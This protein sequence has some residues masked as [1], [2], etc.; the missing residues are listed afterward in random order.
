MAAG[1]ERYIGVADVDVGSV[2]G[3]HVDVLLVDA[4]A[5]AVAAAESVGNASLPSS[6]ALP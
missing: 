2:V 5:L 4:V 1:Y 6:D 3:E